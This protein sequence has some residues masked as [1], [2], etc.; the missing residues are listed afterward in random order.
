MRSC[1]SL[2]SG[3]WQIGTEA[4]G[5]IKEEEEAAACISDLYLGY[6]SGVYY[7]QILFTRIYIY[8]ICALHVLKLTVCM[9]L[10]TINVL[11]VLILI[12]YIVTKLSYL[13]RH[14]LCLHK[15]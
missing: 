9:C 10:H 2:S 13:Y 4:C 15:V 3:Q 5:C 7:I 1:S 12:N 8:C 6:S 11:H 14:I